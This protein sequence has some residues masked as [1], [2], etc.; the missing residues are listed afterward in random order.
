MTNVVGVS[1]RQQAPQ[2]SRRF[3]PTLSMN[4]SHS[5]RTVSLLFLDAKISIGRGRARTAS[6]ELA[7]DFDSPAL[8][9]NNNRP[10]RSVLREITRDVERTRPWRVRRAI[11]PKTRIIRRMRS[12]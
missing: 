12:G 3:G 9:T 1:T 10:A 2:H 11:S 5:S 7:R 6:G 4:V 8:L